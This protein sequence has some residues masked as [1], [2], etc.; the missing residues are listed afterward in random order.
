MEIN[1]ETMDQITVVKI[2]GDIDG[3]SAPEAQAKILPLIQADCKL[4]VDMSE[5]AYM[6]S[7][8]L[9]MLLSMHRQAAS[10]KGQLV[11]V[12]LSEDIEDT[13]SATGFLNFFKT[14]DTVAAGLATLK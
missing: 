6:S 7:A 2:T 1:V 3:K 12:G 9:R 5:V 13:M 4:L 11:L 10:S 14:H 8:G